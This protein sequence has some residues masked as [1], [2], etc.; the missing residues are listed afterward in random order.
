MIS[1]THNQPIFI[2]SL[3]RAGS[4]YVF[5]VFRRSS[6]GYWAYQEPVHEIIMIA[7]NNPDVLSGFTSEALAPL[8]HPQLEKP[9]FYELQQ[10]HQAW[11]PVV[12][13]R[14]IYDDYFG[15]T[16]V[17]P[18]QHYY[19]ALIDA[20]PARPVMQDCRTASRI[21]AIKQALGGVHVYLWRNPWDQ[22]WSFKIN[23]YFD[24]ACQ[25][26][27]GAHGVPPFIVR[28]RD[29]IGYQPFHHDDI[30]EEFQHFKQHPLS[31]ENSYLI[32]YTLWCHGLIEGTSQAD[33]MINIDALSTSD[34]YRNDTEMRFV[35]LDIPGVDFSDC[36]VPQAFFDSYDTAF[37][38]GIES[39]AYGLLLASGVSQEIIDKIRQTQT[40][41]APDRNETTVTL[42]RDLHRTRE[43]VLRFQTSEAN[44][45]QELYQMIDNLQVH[46][47]S[48]NHDLGKTE[49]RSLEIQEQLQCSQSEVNQVTESM[50]AIQQQANTEKYE[51]RQQHQE[52]VADMQRQHAE[53]E[54]FAAERIQHLNNIL[55]QLQANTVAR[56]QH[57]AEKAAA[58][59]AELSGL[60]RA[61]VQREQD[62]STQMQAVQQQANTEKYE[63]SQQHHEVVAD[64]QRQHAE[65]ERFAAERIQHLNNILQQLQT[66]TVAREQHHA[67]KA[68]ALQAELTLLLRAQVQREQDFSAQLQAIQRQADAD[69]D[70]LNQQH[71]QEQLQHIQ[72]QQ[73][74]NIAQQK[75]NNELLYQQEANLLAVAEVSALEEQLTDLRLWEKQL[76]NSLAQQIGHA[77]TLAH[78]IKDIQSTWLWRFYMLFRQKRWPSI[79]LIN[80][81]ELINFTNASLTHEK[82]AANNYHQTATTQHYID[83][84][85]PFTPN[86]TAPQPTSEFS[87]MLP[88]QHIYELFIFDDREFINVTY[89]TLLGREPDP[90]GMNY[91]L[92]RLRMGYGKAAIIV[93]LANSSE[94]RPHGNI[95]GLANLIK[96][97]QLATHWFFGLFTRRQ[98]IERLMQ[99]NIEEL[100]R[101]IGGI[102]QINTAIQTLPSVIDAHARRIEANLTHL[103]L[104]TNEG[105]T[106]H[107]AIE[108]DNFTN[109][110]PAHSPEPE[111]LKQLTPR[112][113][114]IY[115]QLKK[116]VAQQTGNNS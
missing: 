15:A 2:H 91:Y 65:Q 112:A 71:H 25:I 59:Q 93:Q 75:L 102:T 16:P 27:L 106:A 82:L 54:Q 6:A 100:G 9:Y 1:A 74:S 116:A 79:D 69:K 98:R 7:K 101:V 33:L 89:R 64:M 13:K 70:K 8:R 53:H 49:S 87:D 28:L 47:A 95:K 39:R 17:E 41:F 94:A 36:E 24:A 46:N 56:E 99:R 60:L 110:A 26:I 34:K 32:F 114:D 86:A 20:A 37:F 90:N 107:T 14:I 57:H 5:N 43:A 108:P 4:T 3:W 83:E 96:E 19:Q 21:G 29:E 40:E 97:E 81:I 103:T 80:K 18:L 12:E 76:H 66:E 88:P 30:G 45:I 63:I 11:Q 72:L 84:E 109:V 85:L 31:S 92:G 104:Q 23:N 67:E 68:A 61:Q 44:Q 78:R 111:G 50:Q 22:W 38:N 55:Q 62:F 77:E 35:E 10:T 113:R 52:I 48:L 105:M 42:I 115:F 58:L 73:A 51:I